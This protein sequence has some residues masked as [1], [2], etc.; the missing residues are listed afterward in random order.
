M[1]KHRRLLL[2]GAKEDTRIPYSKA[3]LF[4]SYN[5]NKDNQ[6]YW[7]FND[8]QNNGSIVSDANALGGSCMQTSTAYNW[9]EKNNPY[10]PIS[11]GA[12]T[13]E[14]RIKING[15]LNSFSLR[16][17]KPSSADLTGFY[18]DGS[19]ITINSAGGRFAIDDE[20]VWRAYIL[21]RSAGGYFVHFAV[22]YEY[23][24]NTHLHLSAYIDGNCVFDDDITTLNSNN[25]TTYALDF[26]VGSR[27]EQKLMVNY[28]KYSGNFKPPTKPYKIIQGA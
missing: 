15:A 11:A 6:G 16:I 12:I 2:S 10:F 13:V 21:S 17:S 26:P 27:I 7:Y 20:A 24:D 28:K 8:I 19:Q 9:T 4:M 5:N 3:L 1:S 22:V 14:A 23:I 25:F 18:Y